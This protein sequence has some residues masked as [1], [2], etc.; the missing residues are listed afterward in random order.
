MEVPVSPFDEPGT[1]LGKLRKSRKLSRKLSIK[2]VE[3]P[4]VPPLMSPDV[5]PLNLTVAQK[6]RLSYMF[7]E[8]MYSTSVSDSI[9]RCSTPTDSMCFHCEHYHAEDCCLYVDDTDEDKPRYSRFKQNLEQPTNCTN[10][11]HFSLLP[12]AISGN[13]TPPYF[14]SFTPADPYIFEEKIAKQQKKHQL[15]P[16]PEIAPQLPLIYFRQFFYP[17]TAALQLTV[18]NLIAPPP[19]FQ[20]PQVNPPQKQQMPPQLT[21]LTYQTQQQVP[22]IIPQMQLFPTVYHHEYP[23]FMQQQQ[24]P[25]MTPMTYIN[26]GISFQSQFDLLNH[27]T[28]YYQHHQLPQM[29]PT[30]FY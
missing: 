15:S 7:E 11:Q 13:S 1:P 6:N 25:C 26:A 2:E 3:S 16:P 9:G 8:S 20:T 17:Y 4:Q 30:G 29:I 18:N 5:V 22:P 27:P 24:Q 10:N 12:D 21:P 23:H 19:S 28:L 14:P